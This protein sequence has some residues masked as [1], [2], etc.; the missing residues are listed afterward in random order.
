MSNVVNADL[1][2]IYKQFHL[3]E[4]PIFQNLERISIRKLFKILT[5]TELKNLPTIEAMNFY[6]Y[7]NFFKNRLLYSPTFE[8][9]LAYINLKVVE[10][11]QRIKDSLDEFD[12]M[13]RKTKSES[14]ATWI[15]NNIATLY[16]GQV[17]LD[18]VPSRCDYYDEK[19]TRY[20][21]SNDAA[22]NSVVLAT[23]ESE[24]AAEFTQLSKLFSEVG[25]IIGRD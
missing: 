14:D 9:N 11:K 20:L 1:E 4:V 19:I 12:Q 18:K 25:R 10:L 6:L 22:A 5:I 17:M 3:T 23:I 21:N 15:D 13:L 2:N 16:D 8:Q 24:C 7:C